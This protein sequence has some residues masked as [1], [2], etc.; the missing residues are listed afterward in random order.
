MA[1]I[2]EDTLAEL[3]HPLSP[4][5]DTIMNTADGPLPLPHARITSSH[6]QHT[7]PDAHPHIATL[8]W[9]HVATLALTRDCRTLRSAPNPSS[10]FRPSPWRRPWARRRRM[11]PGP[12][13]CTAPPRSLRTPLP[14]MSRWR[15]LAKPLMRDSTTARH[16]SRTHALR[17]SHH[18]L[19]ELSQVPSHP[20][21]CDINYGRPRNR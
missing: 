8:T 2:R 14:I 10:H 4:N 13:T 1:P 7:I 6:A 21:K 20:F 12:L 11:P 18:R 15:P 9:K 3:T 17:R 19:E 16:V 5:A